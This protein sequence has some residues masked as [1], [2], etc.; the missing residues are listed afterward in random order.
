MSDFLLQTNCSG[1]C[2]RLSILFVNV[3]P[4][5]FK[6]G[7]T[8]SK[9]ESYLLFRT[10]I[11]AEVSNITSLK[12]ISS[13]ST[14]FNCPEVTFVIVKLENRMLGNG[15]NINLHGDK[16]KAKNLNVN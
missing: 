15:C 14:N 10:M 13:L 5:I 16:T 1:V 7:L 2:S 11:A 3:Q 9:I 4:L 12:T 6:D 8:T